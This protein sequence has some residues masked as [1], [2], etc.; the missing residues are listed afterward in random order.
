VP[1]ALA[2]AAITQSAPGNQELEQFDRR[3][4]EHVILASTL[5]LGVFD[6]NRIDHRR[7]DWDPYSTGRRR[8]RDLDGRHR[9]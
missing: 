2:L 4:P 3:Q 8:W 7:L 5:G 6:A 9:A 1:D